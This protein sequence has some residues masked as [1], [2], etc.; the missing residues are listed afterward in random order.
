MAPSVRTKANAIMEQDAVK[1]TEA[2]FER[3]ADANF[4]RMH[5]FVDMAMQTGRSSL[6]AAGEKSIQASKL[7]VETTTKTLAFSQ[8]AAAE[9]AEHLMRMTKTHDLKEATQLQSEFI[10]ARLNAFQDYLKDISSAAEA[11]LGGAEPK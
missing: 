8:A 7:A 5:K 11:M 4:E 2:G 9:T 6:N 1:R 3:E 10:R